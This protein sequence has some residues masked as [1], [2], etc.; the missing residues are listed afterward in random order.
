M[1]TRRALVIGTG[2][3]GL[4]TAH[5]LRRSDWDVVLL[6]GAVPCAFTRTAAG[7]DAARRLGLRLE[8]DVAADLRRR[9]GDSVSY[10]VGRVRSLCPDDCGV[11]VTFSNGDEDWFDLVTEPAS[12]LGTSLALVAAEMLGDALDIF[13]DTDEALH[14]WDENLRPFKGDPPAVSVSRRRE[15]R[16]AGPD[17][18]HSPG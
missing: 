4:A 5:R 12:D 10:R 7:L 16:A 11:T 13:C 9:L 6:G 1:A 14:W 17:R 3:A 2:I 8:P 18:A 15:C